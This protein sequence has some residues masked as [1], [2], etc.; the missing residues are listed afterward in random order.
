MSMGQVA[1]AEQQLT[2][3]LRSPGI[4]VDLRILASLNLAIVYLR[5]GRERELSDLLATLNPDGLA[6]QSQSLKAAAF[7]V[8]G[9]NAFLKARFADAKRFLRETLKIANSEDLNRLT[10]CSLVLLGHIFYSLGSHRES[11]NMV[12]PAKQLAS[13]IPDIQ[14]ELWATALLADLFR[15]EGN[16]VRM[17][18]S[19]AAHQLF[20]QQL[21][22]DQCSAAAQPEHEYIHWDPLQQQQS[23]Q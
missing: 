5:V 2:R 21:L 20:Q 23:H 14:I 11:M 9:L 22:Q 19:S 16:V 12:T 7:Y 18:E 8:M 3:V 15:D 17:N 1:E 13:K 4:S 6:S 10:S